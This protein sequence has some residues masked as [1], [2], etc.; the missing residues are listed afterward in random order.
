[1]DIEGFDAFWQKVLSGCP[2]WSAEEESVL[3]EMKRTAFIS[4][5][6]KD[7]AWGAISDA[8]ASGANI[9]VVRNQNGGLDI[10]AAVPDPISEP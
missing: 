5:L 4:W 6:M 3:A 9:E 1:M 7:P 8:I 2:T 10:L